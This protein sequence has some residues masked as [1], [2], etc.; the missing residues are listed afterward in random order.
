MY[1]VSEDLSI[2]YI[3]NPNGW[4]FQ[5]SG[6]EVFISPSGQVLPPSGS[7]LNAIK[8]KAWG[9]GTVSRYQ[10][11]SI[12]NHTMNMILEAEG[13]IY[14]IESEGIFINMDDNSVTGTAKIN[15]IMYDINIELA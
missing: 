6:F 8:M 7:G 11:T 5:V 12:Q 9:T 13:H 4:R 10:G 2:G 14:S 15:G 1:D 3:S